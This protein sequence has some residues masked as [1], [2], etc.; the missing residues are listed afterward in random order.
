MT[1]PGKGGRPSK[2]TP[3]TKQK[4]LTA[5]AG[6]NYQI[7]ALALAGLSRQSYSVWQERA[8]NGEEEYM[9]FFEKVRQ[10]EAYAEAE[11]IKNIKQAADAGN[12]TASAWM[13]ER[14]HPDRWGRKDK[15]EADV[16]VAGNFT[17][18]F[19]KGMGED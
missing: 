15:V 4:I 19:D 7:I 2:F 6:G 18:T 5:L 3:E 12:W 11:R 9:E 8:E 17:V 13:L 14:K 10:A 16:N 1:V